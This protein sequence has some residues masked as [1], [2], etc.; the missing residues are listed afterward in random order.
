[1]SDHTW[2]ASFKE[3]NCGNRTNVPARIISQDFKKVTIA[4]Q[5]SES[6]KSNSK[7]QFNFR[8]RE[9]WMESLMSLFNTRIAKLQ[10]LVIAWNTLFLSLVQS[11]S[12][13]SLLLLFA[14][15]M[16][17]TTSITDLS[18]VDAKL[19]EMELQLHSIKDRLRD[20]TLAIPKAKVPLS[21]SLC[22]SIFLW[23]VSELGFCS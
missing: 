16:Y 4:W 23:L 12:S 21:L 17:R 7:I 5:R 10:D 14:I 1:M 18:T 11:G 13:T 8:E 2:D 19:K 6:K 3:K 20:E 15:S 9:R 22:V